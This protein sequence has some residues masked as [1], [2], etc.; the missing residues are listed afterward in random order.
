MRDKLKAKEYHRIYWLTIKKERNRKRFLHSCAV[1]GRP[2]TTKGAERCSSCV[3]K[4]LIGE[5]ASHWKGGRIINRGYIYLYKPDH[6]R[7]GRR[8]YVSEHILIWEQVNNKLLPDGWIIHHLN[9]IK[10]DNRPENLLAMPYQKHSVAL[11]Q[12]AL[13]KRI[14]EL[15][16]KL[17]NQY[18]LL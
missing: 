16:G 13:Q 11:L 12:Q 17:R 14:R 18:L 5:K 15:E 10:T 1:C 4:S 2:I 3:S 6:P 8:K 9:G 7:A